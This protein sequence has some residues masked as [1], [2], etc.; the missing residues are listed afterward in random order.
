[1]VKLA[2]EPCQIGKQRLP[3]VGQRRNLEP[4]LSKRLSQCCFTT[5]RSRAMAYVH[6]IQHLRVRLEIRVNCVEEL[7]GLEASCGGEHVW[8]GCII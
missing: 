3:V 6:G 5:V 8:M 2:L 7:G 4:I 1:M